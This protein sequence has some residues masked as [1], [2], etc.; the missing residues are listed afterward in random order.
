[1]SEKLI[2]FDLSYPGQDNHKFTVT[3]KDRHSDT[4]LSF[5]PVGFSCMKLYMNITSEQ[6]TYFRAKISPEWD[7]EQGFYYIPY[8]PEAAGPTE[9]WNS[10]LNSQLKWVVWGPHIRQ[11]GTVLWNA[12]KLN[13]KTFLW[14]SAL[15]RKNRRVRNKTVVAG[16]AP[17]TLT[18]TDPLRNLCYLPLLAILLIAD[19]QVLVPKVSGRGQGNFPLMI[20][21]EFHW[22]ILKL[23]NV[24]NNNIN[25]WHI[26]KT[27]FICQ[28]LPQFWPS[29]AIL[30][31]DTSKQG[32]KGLTVSAQTG[33]D[34]KVHSNSI[35]IH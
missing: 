23:I 9:Q 22:I 11:W 17:P 5:L 30:S 14:H 19:F 29:W 26:S 25:S 6:G 33:T 13:W 28:A 8:H 4:F 32:Y 35:L 2:A 21:Q 24:N 18:S 10:L 15:I 20:Q 3:E 1:M 7:H 31:N 27:P 16:I 12:I 34:P